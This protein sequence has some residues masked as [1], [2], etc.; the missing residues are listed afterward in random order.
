MT[1]VTAA[2]ASSRTASTRNVAMVIDAAKSGASPEASSTAA[3]MPSGSSAAPA[4]P[5]TNADTK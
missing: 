5:A 1:A 2:K 4:S 3:A